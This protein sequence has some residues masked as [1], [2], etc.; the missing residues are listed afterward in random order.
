M[1]EDNSGSI[2][3]KQ[4]LKLRWRQLVPDAKVRGT[5]LIAHGYAEHMGRYQNVFDTLL[6]AGIQVFG[7]DHQGHGN[8]EGKRGYVERLG[9]YTVDMHQ[10]YAEVIVPRLAGHKLFLLGHSMGS[11]IA[12][13]YAVAHHSEL[14]GLILS[15]TGNTMSGTPKLLTALASLLSMLVPKLGIKSPFPTSFISHDPEVCA[16][17]DAD[18]LVYAPDITVRLGA[19]MYQGCLD[20]AVALAPLTLPLLI[21]YGSLDVSFA[22]QRELFESYAG[23]DKTFKCY[24]GAKHE[25]YNELPEWKDQSLGDLRSW[26]EARL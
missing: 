20:G 12:M 14:G 11:V 16:A 9:D 21:Q 22:G 13:H 2:T 24:E 10:L 4:G 1:P 5:V 7:L 19:E 6:P 17:Y 25:T 3:N 18:P 15:G 8:S 23:E 26:V